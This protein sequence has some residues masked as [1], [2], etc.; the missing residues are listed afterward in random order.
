SASSPTGARAH[1]PG[2]VP[3]TPAVGSSSTT[4]VSKCP[5]VFVGLMPTYILY[6][7]FSRQPLQQLQHILA[8][9]VDRCCIVLGQRLGYFLHASLAVAELE[10]CDGGLVRR[11]N[12]LRR[13]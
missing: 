3:L 7:S 12:A 2:D 6:I 5:F 11:Q 9:H 4:S 13:Q 8:D 1:S 10:H